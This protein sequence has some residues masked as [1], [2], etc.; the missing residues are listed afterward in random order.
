MFDPGPD[1]GLGAVLRAFRV[2]QGLVAVALLV[3]KVLRSRG[4]LSDHFT[5]P[6]IGR[7]TPYTSF[8]AMKQVGQQLAVVHIGRRGGNRMDQLALAVHANV[9]LHAE[10]PLVSLLRLVHLRVP[11]PVPVLGGAHCQPVKLVVMRQYRLDKYDVD[12]TITPTIAI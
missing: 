8:L 5:L 4:M 1:S 2:C 7:V 12:A 6:V 3:R 10:V 9:S 11:L